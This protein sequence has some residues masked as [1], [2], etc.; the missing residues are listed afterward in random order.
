MPECGCNCFT[1][2]VVILVAAGGAAGIIIYQEKT[3]NEIP[4]IGEHFPNIT[5]VKD[6]W[7]DIDWPDLDFD[8]TDI[9]SSEPD[10]SG[11]GGIVSLEYSWK[12]KKGEGLE[13]KIANALSADWHSYFDKAVAD[14]DNGTPDVMSLQT[15]VV[16][17]DPECK[18][19][20]GIMKVC[21]KD[22]GETGWKGINEIL[23]QGSTI[24]A[25]IAK[26]NEFYLG[27]NASGFG[28]KIEDHRQY[29][30]C[31]EI[32]HGFGLP[33]Q[34]EDFT[35]K[36]LNSCMDYSNSPE[37]NLVPNQ[38]DWDSINTLYG[39]PEADGESRHLENGKRVV[40]RGPQRFLRKTMK[41]DLNGEKVDKHIYYLSA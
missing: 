2:M 11:E 31:H 18:P 21:N 39:E 7:D 1:L 12:S 29:T 13:L 38:V 22:Y 24:V 27:D 8:F 25:S 19:E 37:N 40:F 10:D 4:F 17:E 3:G 34:D 20:S 5:E 14:W 16:S 41:Y 30:M 9:I 28:S 32:G 23:T 35:N 36:D 33:H 15:S 26:M 6:A